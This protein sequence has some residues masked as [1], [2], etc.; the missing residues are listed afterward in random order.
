MRFEDDEPVFRKSRL[1]TNRY[2]YNPNNPVGLALIVISV[3]LVGGMLL[4]M[5]F[6]AATITLYGTRSPSDSGSRLPATCRPPS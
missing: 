6:R 5:H 4:L 1:G 2:E 3:L